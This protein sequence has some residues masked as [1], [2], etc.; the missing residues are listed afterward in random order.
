MQLARA[1]LFAAGMFACGAEITTVGEPGPAPTDPPI[2]TGN[3]APPAPSAD[4]PKVPPKDGYVY[5]YSIEWAEQSGVSRFG[6]WSSA[7]FGEPVLSGEPLSGCV[8]RVDEPGEAAPPPPVRVSDS[9]GTIDIE[10]TLGAEK[11]DLALWFDTKN[12]LYEAFGQE[13]AGP[14]SGAIRFR[15]R[16][17]AVPAFSV[18]LVPQVPV[19]VVSPAIAS[20]VGPRDL[21]VSWTSDPAADLTLVVVTALTKE[22]R[23]AATKG[24]EL[25]IPAALMTEVLDDEMADSVDLMVYTGKSATLDVG[26]YRVRVQHDSSMYIYLLKE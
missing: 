8:L 19:K 11:K 22:I 23:C 14:A 12:E 18:D 21:S 26:D 15:A 17:G 16:G 7:W 3:P 13:V 24:N 5:V 1:A 10:A 20:K 25:T 4:L 6:A 2:G 9:A